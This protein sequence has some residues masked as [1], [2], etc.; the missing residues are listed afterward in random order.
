MLRRVAGFSESIDQ[1]RRAHARATRYIVSA[2]WVGAGVRSGSDDN[3]ARSYLLWGLLFTGIVRATNN[4]RPREK[5]QLGLRATLNLP[6]TTEELCQN[7]ASDE[8]F[9]LPDFS[10]CRD[11]FRCDRSGGQG[12]IRLAAVRCPTGLAFDINRQVC[13]WKRNVRNCDQLEKPLK[14]KPLLNTDNPICPQGQL[15]CGDG[16]CLPKPLF[17]DG[18][19]DCDDESDENACG[20]DEDPN[21]AP[22]CD[23][24]QCVLPDCFCSADG[25]QIPGNLNPSNTPQMITITFSGAVNF[26]NVDLYQDLFKEERKN[27]NGCQIKATFFVSHKYTNYSAVQELHRKGHEIAVFSI[28]NKEDPEYWTHGSYDDWLTEMAGARLIIERFSNITDNSIIGVRAPFLRV[29]GNTQFEMMTDQLFIYDA[30]ITAPLSRMPLW[31]Y[32]MYFRMPHKC[33]GNAQN[34]PSR[35]HPVWEM[36][37][38]EL[39]RRDDPEFDENL[40]GCHFVDSCSNIR[41]GKQFRHLLEHN[42]QRHYQTNRAPLG[43]HFQAAWLE[44]NKDFKKELIKFIIDKTS[45][46]DVYFVTML[47]VIQWMQSPTEVTGIRDF[48]EWKEKCDV[49]GLPYCS[50]PNVCPLHTRELREETLNLHTCMDCP[51]NYPWLLDPTGDGIDIV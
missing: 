35:S 36:V 4:F 19:H 39:D 26:D 32:T 16:V 13:D 31:P 5:R 25:T 27:A 17:C 28:S 44:S 47:Q 22:E 18:K 50:L 41:T 12:P 48:D 43:L 45:Q 30:S 11:V 3:M 1:R 10:D 14:I 9:R 42:F 8:F 38:N 6:V 46:N 21:R 40:A 37:V 15:A 23:K 29:G 34:C 51:R 20:V 7:K 33:H 2:T 49:K 24:Q